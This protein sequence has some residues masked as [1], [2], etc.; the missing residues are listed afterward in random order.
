MKDRVTI[1]WC[2]V[3]LRRRFRP[4]EHGWVMDLKTEAAVGPFV[5][6]VYIS[7]IVLRSDDS[8]KPSWDHHEKRPLQWE[9]C[10][11]KE[12]RKKTCVD[13]GRR[14]HA[15]SRDFPKL[16]CD[17]PQSSWFLNVKLRP[18][19]GKVSLKSWLWK[20]L[21][22]C[23]SVSA[24]KPLA[25]C[26]F[27]LFCPGPQGNSGLT[28]IFYSW[29]LRVNNPQMPTWPTAL[30]FALELEAKDGNWSLVGPEARGSGGSK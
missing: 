1:T 22:H 7:W 25:N 27:E 9:D 15:D 30:V 17:S 3:S 18:L 26:H 19:P 11:P 23:S 20:Q 2:W 8:W 24:Q 5:Q 16:P 29:Y 10:L 28:A 4:L 14:R 12:W 13:P 21:V 6:W